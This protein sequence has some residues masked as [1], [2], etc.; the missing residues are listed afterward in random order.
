VVADD[1]LVNELAPRVHNS[2]HW[3]QQG[4]VISQF[5]NHLR[6]ILGLPLGNTS[7]HGYAG[8]VNILGDPPGPACYAELGGT[9]SLHWYDKEPRPGRK[10]GHVAVAGLAE[11]DVA[12]HLDRVE[13]ALY[14]Q[15]HT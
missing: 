12:D 14:G 2:G 3:T 7:L 13:R 1:V 15:V 11:D 6:A 5:E 8:L 4:N 10:L 9:A